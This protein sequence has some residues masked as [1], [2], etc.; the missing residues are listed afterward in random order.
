MTATGGEGS[1]GSPAGTSGIRSLAANGGVRG[2]A[3]QPPS[4]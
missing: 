2:G 3:E 1:P 4:R